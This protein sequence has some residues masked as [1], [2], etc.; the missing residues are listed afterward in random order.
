MA[1]GLLCTL[2]GFIEFNWVGAVI[3]LAIA[4]LLATFEVPFVYKCFEVCFL[5]LGGLEV[6]ARGEG[7]GGSVAGGGYVGTICRWYCVFIFI[8]MGLVLS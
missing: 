8:F 5:C 6:T 7:G 1:G 2:L 4:M 3:A